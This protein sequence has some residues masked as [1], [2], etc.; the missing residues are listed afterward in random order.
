MRIYIEQHPNSE[1]RTFHTSE[2]FTNRTHVSLGKD[3]HG[4]P[5]KPYAKRLVAFASAVGLLKE[6]QEVGI[7]KNN[8]S[9]TRN[10]AYSWGEVEQAVIP[11]IEKFFK[12][13]ATVEVQERAAWMDRPQRDYA[14][15]DYGS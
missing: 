3:Y 10:P 15:Q 5:D 12:S 6:V 11:K 1:M 13:A 14:D 4:T 7:H 8:I 9:V 2:N